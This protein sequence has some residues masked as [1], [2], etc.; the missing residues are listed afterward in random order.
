[1]LMKNLFLIFG[2]IICQIA[3]C[4]PTN[5]Q[6]NL[7]NGLTIDVY[8]KYSKVIDFI[9]QN[10]DFNSDSLSFFLAPNNSLEIVDQAFLD[11][12]TVRGLFS[13]DFYKN[14]TFENMQEN[15]IVFKS[16]R[17]RFYSKNED[18]ILISNDFDPQKI[19]KEVNM[20]KSYKINNNTILNLLE[21]TIK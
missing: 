19:T 5:A 15:K 9:Q 2:F 4:V 7:K 16:G 1:M 6:V 8:N 10:V 13:I 18:H 11:N 21:D 17:L 14:H 12:H 3:F 20:I